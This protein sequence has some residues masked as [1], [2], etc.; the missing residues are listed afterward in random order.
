M[1]RYFLSLTPSEKKYS[2]GASVVAASREPIITA[3]GGGA[4][5]VPP[6]HNPPIAPAQLPAPLRPAQSPAD[7][8]TCGCSQGQ[9][10]DHLPHSLDATI[11]YDWHPKAPGILSHLVHGSALR[12]TT[13]HHCGRGRKTEMSPQQRGQRPDPFSSCPTSSQEKGQASM[14]FLRDRWVAANNTRVIVTPNTQTTPSMTALWGILIGEGSVLALRVLHPLH[15]RTQ[16]W[17]PPASPLSIY[18]FPFEASFAK[19]VARVIMTS[20]GILPSICL[21]VQGP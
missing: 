3:V 14:M 16:A 4:G 11:S 10:L 2:P 17:W 19:P 18:K 8:L 5:S 21:I 7:P 1:P 12:P 6:A 15:W 20:F 9:G 13:G